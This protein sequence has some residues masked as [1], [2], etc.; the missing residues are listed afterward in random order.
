MAVASAIRERFRGGA[1]LVVGHSDTVPAIVG[2]LG[3]P[4]LERLCEPTEYASLFTV[5]L[6][7]GAAV[8]LARSWYGRPDPPKPPECRAPRR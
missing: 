8:S 2:A 3:G 5:V 7:D 6:A 4:V 1:V